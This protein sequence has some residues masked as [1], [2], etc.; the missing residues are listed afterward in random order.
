MYDDNDFIASLSLGS[1][2]L[3]GPNGSVVVTRLG[4]VVPS[5][6]S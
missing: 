1:S 4:M 6:A 5:E 2:S 3:A